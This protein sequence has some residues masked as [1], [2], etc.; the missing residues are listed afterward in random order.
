MLSHATQ[1]VM[2]AA[3]C[4]HL[5]TKL[6]PGAA[7]TCQRGCFLH[8]HFRLLAQQLQNLQHLPSSMTWSADIRPWER[9]CRLQLAC[10]MRRGGCAS[11]DLLTCECSKL[12]QAGQATDSS[13]CSTRPHAS[14]TRVL[15]S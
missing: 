9:L 3:R 7:L 13:P 4:L 5:P 12:H 1:K 6:Q 8:Q 10:L 11:A 15:H 2:Q 14:E